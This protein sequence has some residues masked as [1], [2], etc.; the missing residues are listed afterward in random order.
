MRSLKDDLSKEEMEI[1]YGLVG[2]IENVAKYLGI[3]ESEVRVL[4]LRSPVLRVKEM[5]DPQF[6]K[7]FLAAGGA[8]AA[9]KRLFVSSA[10]ILSELTR[11]GYRKEDPVNWLKLRGDLERLG[12]V[13]FVAASYGATCS[14]VRQR[15]KEMGFDPKDVVRIEASGKYTAALGRN[16]ELAFAEWRG[17]KIIKD[18]NKVDG[19][20]ADTDFVDAEFGRVN[21][22]SSKGYKSKRTGRLYFKI[23][24]EGLSQSDYLAAALYDPQREK[25]LYWW[26]RPVSLV[27]V[28]LKTISLHEDDLE[29]LNGCS[30]DIVI[31]ANLEL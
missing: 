24:T 27:N 30:A 26:V 20:K 16:A 21:V 13:A 15:C 18:C 8:D 7:V 3:P 6:L 1:L 2:S 4:K 12:S 22:K 9:A 25:V 11:R 31:Q 5:A 14:E 17:E 23:N 29:G 19:S 10:F 28:N